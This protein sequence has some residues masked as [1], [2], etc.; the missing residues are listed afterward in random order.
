MTTD[1]HR[2]HV[3]TT[4]QVLFTDEDHEVQL[5]AQEKIKGGFLSQ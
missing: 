1:P 5:K 2:G 3:T 4:E